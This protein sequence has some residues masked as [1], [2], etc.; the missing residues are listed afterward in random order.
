MKASIKA[1][2]ITTIAMLIVAGC[3]TTQR[4]EY[5]TRTTHVRIGKS[6]LDQYGRSGWEL[7]QFTLIPAD[8]TGT[9][10]L[11]ATN[12]M[13]SVEYEYIFKRPKK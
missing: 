1:W 9:N 8:K 3:A 5:K 12:V 6:I 4:W 11:S 10:D 13:S 7:V 2:F